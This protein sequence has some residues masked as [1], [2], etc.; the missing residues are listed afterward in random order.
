MRMGTNNL[1]YYAI[2]MLAGVWCMA[3]MTSGCHMDAG[4][5]LVHGTDDKRVRRR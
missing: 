5:C 4:G 2:W 1:R 3:L